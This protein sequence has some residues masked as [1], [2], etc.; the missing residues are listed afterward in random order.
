MSTGMFDEEIIA[1]A[2]R[3]D[4]R[5]MEEQRNQLAYEP[6]D[7]AMNAHD[8]KHMNEFMQNSL[9]E[10]K[11]EYAKQYPDKAEKI[12][13]RV[14]AAAYVKTKGGTKVF[15]DVAQ[16]ICCPVRVA[17]TQKAIL[18]EV[19]ALNPIASV[20]NNLWNKPLF[21]W[22]ITELEN[23][24]RGQGVDP[25]VIKGCKTLADA[26]KALYAHR[27]G[28]Q[29]VLKATVKVAIDDR[30]VMVGKNSYPI[31]NRTTKGYSY[32]SIRIGK[33]NKRQWVHLDLLKEFLIG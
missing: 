8:I 18:E 32:P 3:I 4:Q 21:A 25:Q 1:E 12:G 33:G 17:L 9:K 24:A 30:Q 11:A 27:K 10:A 22:Q 2:A 28:A 13:Y 16:R 23:Q 20:Q 31:Q 29:A 19:K 14:Q 7:Y 26:R 15:K 5:L 6:Q